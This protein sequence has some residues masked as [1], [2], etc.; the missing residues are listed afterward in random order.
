MGTGAAIA[1]RVREREE[2][3][4]RA[5]G[6]VVELPLTASCEVGGDTRVHEGVERMARARGGA[7]VA[8]Y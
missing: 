6:S 8:S 7:A 1:S 4:G 5:G 2:A 3:G